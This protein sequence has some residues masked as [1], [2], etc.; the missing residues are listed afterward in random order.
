MNPDD[1]DITIEAADRLLCLADLY[2]FVKSA[3]PHLDQ[4]H[5]F[6]PLWHQRVLC[7][8]LQAYYRREIKHLVVNMPPG[9]GKPLDV[10]TPVLMAD[11]SQKRLGE[12]I[13]GDEVIGKSGKPHPVSAVHEQGELPCLEIT[14][15]SGR[16]VRASPDHSFLTSGGWITAGRLRPGSLLVCIDGEHLHESVISVAPC[17]KR[18]CRCLTVD[19]DQSFC[20]N[21]IVVHNSVICS[22]LFPTW[23]WANDPSQKLLCASY[24]QKVALSF[25][26]SARYLI[27]DDWYGAFW[28]R[29]EGPPVKLRGDANQMG[30][31]E[32]T[33]G[34][35]R[36]SGPVGT[37]FSTHPNFIIID[38][39]YNPEEAA[40][41]REREAVERWYFDNVATRGIALGAGH[42]INMQRLHP[43]DL[44]GILEKIQEREGQGDF[45]FLKL[46]ME[47]D[48]KLVVPNPLG[49]TDFR[50]VP[51][52]LLCPELIDAQTVKE[53]KARMRPHIYAAQFQQQPAAAKGDMIQRQWLEN[54][55][56]T[57]LPN[58][59]Q[60][61]ASVRFWDKA[62][63]DSERSDWT[64]GVLMLYDGTYFYVADV[65]RFQ[66][67]SHERDTRIQQVA[68]A[69]A[70][71]W[72][73]YVV[74]MEEEYGPGKQ[75]AEI[76]I[77]SLA[78]FRL[79][80]RRPRKGKPGPGDDNP[81]AWEA[82]IIQLAAGNIK[83]LDAHWT[84][85]FIDEHSEAPNGEHDD[86]IDAAS[87]ALEEL[88]IHGRRGK[89]IRPL[90]CSVAKDRRLLQDKARYDPLAEVLEDI[91]GLESHDD[92]ISRNW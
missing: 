89:I 48:P 53:R 70:D 14:T 68:Q 28:D 59:P 56:V 66:A 69:D 43:R 13:A 83:V 46:P 10:D 67:K 52:Q 16:S 50:T 3:W 27:Q 6:K 84:Q 75:G 74:A 8:H 60:I 65:S 4:G 58:V 34:G 37:G 5:D 78:G 55:V 33:A 11:R 73:N 92:W 45:V 23:I 88:A 35:W 39:P 12:I 62:Y 81:G 38:D 17:G 72:P 31:Y 41:E 20:A 2:H 64:V 7:E 51:N 22:V 82:Y 32:T 36:L 49:F 77:R 57:A 15:T 9:I 80:V 44:C 85:K 86:Q 79:R 71:R 61:E 54:N 87:G 91:A 25:A 24:Q 29:T 90:L 63:S 76:S 30:Y 1:L 47:Y 26:R 40:S 18:P 21:N 42:L 19:E